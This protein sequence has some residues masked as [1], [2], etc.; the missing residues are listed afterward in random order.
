LPFSS[1][2]SSS[3][4]S[5]LGPNSQI[6][7]LSISF[8]QGYLLAALLYLLLLSGLVPSFCCCSNSSIPFVQS[9]NLL[10]LPS[11]VGPDRQ[12]QLILAKLLRR[13]LL[14]ACNAISTLIC[15]QVL[16]MSGRLMLLCQI[17]AACSQIPIALGF[18]PPKLLERS[19]SQPRS[20]KQSPCCPDFLS[21]SL[22]TSCGCFRLRG[23]GRKLGGRSRVVTGNAWRC[24]FSPAV[25]AIPGSRNLG[26]SA[27]M[28]E[29]AVDDLLIRPA[30]E[31]D[32]EKWLEMRYRFTSQTSHLIQRVLC[33]E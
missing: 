12:V 2:S 18:A 10:G 23:P 5:S 33:C 19:L 29:T 1:S 8:S 20:L 31:G 11:G 13:S 24:T 30:N 4:S 27:N 25:P 22:G 9:S 32:F 6:Y 28:K 17:S 14:A 7:L 15:L 21:C 26:L 16:R 3:S